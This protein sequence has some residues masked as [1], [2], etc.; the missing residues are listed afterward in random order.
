MSQTSD[1]SHPKE[2]PQEE[3][4]A[5]LGQQLIRARKKLALS[6]SD[7]AAKLYLSVPVIESLEQDS[8][9][10]S[11]NT[12]YSK[13]Y[14]KS[15]ANLVGLPIPDMMALFE[16]QYQQTTTKKMQSFSKRN[17]EKAHNNYLNWVSLFILVLLICGMFWWWWQQD[18]M[19]SLAIDANNDVSIAQS[20]GAQ[21]GVNIS[22]PQT[23]NFVGISSQSNA[24]LVVLLEGDVLDSTQNADV[25]SANDEVTTDEP[26]ANDIQIV[27]A[28]FTFSKDCWV[29]ITDS[30]NAI[31]AIGI[32]KAG[33]IMPINGVPPFEV[34]LGAPESVT[35]TYQ[36]EVLDITPYIT[37][38]TA[39]FSVPL[40][41]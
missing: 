33:R 22:L 18:T 25:V 41:N 34:I 8:V 29:K 35:I 20:V 30:T 1:N 19:T 23:D 17:L 27:Q 5:S 36:G 14:L 12:L 16:I 2:Q 6:T 15:Y 10:S 39:R 32:K 24:Q 21:P 4:Q 40:D 31:L 28:S 11:L 13:G 7:I 9:D 3:Q 37:D 38:K 26:A